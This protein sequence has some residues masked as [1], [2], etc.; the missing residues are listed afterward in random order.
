[1][2]FWDYIL[3]YLLA[4][5]AVYVLARVIFTAFHRSKADFLRRYFHGTSETK[6]H[7]GSGA[8]DPPGF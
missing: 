1:M 5:P 3:L 4:L 8:D 2:T 6:G 7:N